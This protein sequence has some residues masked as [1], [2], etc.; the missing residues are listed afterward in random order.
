MTLR[1]IGRKQQLW[2]MPLLPKELIF[3]IRGKRRMSVL[4]KR[5]GEREIV[6]FFYFLKN[7]LH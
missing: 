1:G 6:G 7:I 3:P 5:K 4:T 2:R